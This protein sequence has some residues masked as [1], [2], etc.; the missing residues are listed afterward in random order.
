MWVSLIIADSGWSSSW[1][2]IIGLSES[3]NLLLNTEEEFFVHGT[4]AIFITVGESTICGEYECKSTSSSFLFG[5]LT[6]IFSSLRP[7]PRPPSSLKQALPRS[8]LLITADLGEPE[9]ICWGLI[10]SFDPEASLSL[11][12]SLNTSLRLVG[13]SIY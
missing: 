6:P 3:C 2:S 9:T 10:I 11:S 12:S 8:I 1:S 7:I 13:L 5:L 4:A